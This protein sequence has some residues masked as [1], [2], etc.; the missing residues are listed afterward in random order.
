MWY[1]TGWDCTSMTHC[2]ALY[3]LLTLSTKHFKVLFSGWCSVTRFILLSFEP[4]FVIF[5]LWFCMGLRGQR[6]SHLCTRNVNKET[7]K[8]HLSSS[9]CLFYAVDYIL[10]IFCSSELKVCTNLK[11]KSKTIAPSAI[12][13]VRLCWG[14]N[15]REEEEEGDAR[16]HE[17]KEETH[18]GCKEP[19]SKVRGDFS[20]S[21]SN[22]G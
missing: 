2:A 19:Y 12:S 14:T 21:R 10:F 20:W 8:L 11:S 9:F 22:P 4:V 7:L 1:S 5:F 3:W 13:R 15:P 18:H 16:F 6:T 17:G